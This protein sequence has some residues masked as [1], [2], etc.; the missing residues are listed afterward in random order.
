MLERADEKTGGKKIELVFQVGCIPSHE[1]MIY[2]ISTKS[3]VQQRGS[4]VG[5]DPD[6]G[7][8]T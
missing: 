8:L 7:L 3:G 5:E 2:Y 6:P 1:T 4:V